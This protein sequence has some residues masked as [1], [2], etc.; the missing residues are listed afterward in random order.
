M[1]TERVP[2]FCALCRSRCGCVSV[3][4]DGR[5][6]AV[7]PDPSHP[8]G[9]HLCVKGQAAPEL[10]YAPDRLLHP[11]RRTRPRSDPDPGWVRITWDEAL[12]WTAERM[13][14][15]AQREGPEA[16]AFAVTTPAGTAVSDGFPWINRLI[17]AFGSPNMVWGEELCAW[18]RDY[19]TAFTFGADIGTPDFERASCLLL[20]GHN[21][22]TA[23]LAQA[24]AV[25]EAVSRGAA[26]I[27]VDPRRAGPAARA[28][29]WLRVRPGTDGALALGLAAVMLAE[30]WYDRDF[31][32]D[33][34]NGPLLVR[35]D[36]GRLLAAS[37]L[38][39][40]GHPAHRVAWD[41]GAARPVPYDP[42]AGR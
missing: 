34:T 36:T 19:A 15:L 30:G 18:H 37:D 27:V 1:A 33:W 29:Q 39:P 42:A 5:L 21:P 7:E 40:D 17:R 11:M 8:T 9:R 26:L 20:W 2:G 6:V 38:S 13:R 24:T 31:V 35:E 16:V 10:V 12:N 28:D 23:Y 4:E 3:V 41:R 25:S 14:A 22:S 32:R